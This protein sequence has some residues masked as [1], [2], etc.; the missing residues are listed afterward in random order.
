[1]SRT[2]NA[3]IN[4][5]YQSL[6]SPIVKNEDMRIPNVV[7]MNFLPIDDLRMNVNRIKRFEI[8]SSVSWKRK[9]K[10]I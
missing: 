6:I 2:G 4:S 9:F 1:M 8:R 7:N 5:S 10:L 3:F